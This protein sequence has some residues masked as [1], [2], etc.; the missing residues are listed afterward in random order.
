MRIVTLKPRRSILDSFHKFEHGRD[1][2]ESVG[3]TRPSV[4]ITYSRSA[5]L[6]PKEIALLLQALRSISDEPVILG[7][8]FR[9]G[10]NKTYIGIIDKRLVSR[11]DI[12]F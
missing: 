11:N 12:E 7:P 9:C 5:Q 8:S 10:P 4:A 6:I 1:C 3:G 2:V